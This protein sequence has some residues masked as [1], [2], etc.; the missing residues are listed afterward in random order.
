MTRS[1]MATLI[2][3][4]LSDFIAVFYLRISKVCQDKRCWICLP[5]KR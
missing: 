2:L 3:D 5:K 1:V 4:G